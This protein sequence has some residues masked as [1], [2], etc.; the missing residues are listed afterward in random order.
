[1]RI[2]LIAAVAATAIAASVSGATTISSV[3]GPDGVGQRILFNFNSGTPLGL[4][5][6]YSIT[7]GSTAQLAAAPLGDTTPYLVVPGLT[8]GPTGPALLTLGG[9]FTNISFYWGSIDTYN[10]VTFF[11]GA[12]G[13]GTSLGTYTGNLVP[14]AT[15]DGQQATTANNRR[16]FF[17][18]GG[19]TASSV[20]FTSNGRAFEIDDVATAVPEPTI[21]ATL[22]TG[23]GLVGFSLR[24]RRSTAVTA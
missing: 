22:I 11:T 8:D 9:A 16:V 7:T 18:F 20:V 1:M 23:F 2:V 21:W 3:P 15:A 5:G 14:G 17:D 13:T 12:G 10:S 24:R 4:T 6:S 19:A